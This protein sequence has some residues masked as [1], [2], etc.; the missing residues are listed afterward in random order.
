VKTD[1]S[2]YRI[3]VTNEA[4]EIYNNSYSFFREHSRDIESLAAFEDN[5]TFIFHITDISFDGYFAIEIIPE[6]PLT[7]KLFHI[8]I[9]RRLK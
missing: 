6:N 9:L 3:R 2:N 7:V 4:G 8:H 1:S 5:G